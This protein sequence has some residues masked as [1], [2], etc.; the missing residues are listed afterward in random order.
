[1]GF[2]IGLCAAG[3]Q[4]ALGILLIDVVRDELYLKFMNQWSAI[5]DEGRHRFWSDL[6]QDLAEKASGMGAAELLSWLEATASDFIRI[7]NRTRID[8]VEIEGALTNLYGQHVLPEAKGK[9]SMAG[10]S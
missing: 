2:S 8:V 10:H 4:D 6:A 1:V 7:G 3:S 5:S 9:R